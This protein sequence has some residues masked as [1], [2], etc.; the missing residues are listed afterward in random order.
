LGADFARALT[1]ADLVL[2][3]PIYAASEPPEP[4]VDAR[5]IGEPL[6]AAGTPVEYVDDLT[7]LPEA[8]LA[9]AP[10]G[11]MVLCLGAGSITAA[12]A[13]LAERLE[14]KPVAP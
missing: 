14:C 1:G 11:A 12:A 5:T 6:R 4:G 13:R 10:Q 2:L 3:A 7:D 8:L 9:R